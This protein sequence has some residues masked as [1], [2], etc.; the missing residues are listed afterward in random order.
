M[1]Q[2]GPVRCTDPAWR[3]LCLFFRRGAR[4]QHHA[5][6]QPHRPRGHVQA[7]FIKPSRPGER[8]GPGPRTGLHPSRHLLQWP[9]PPGF[10][11]LLRQRAVFCQYP[12]KATVFVRLQQHPARPGRAPAIISN[13]PGWRG[14][15]RWPLSG[16]FFLSVPAC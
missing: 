11:D 12:D 3:L 2:P 5:A 10:R 4:W 9:E 1:E 7:E 13:S 14:T 15:R 8:T 16:P 6:Y